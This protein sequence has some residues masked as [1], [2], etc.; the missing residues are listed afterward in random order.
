MQI[1]LTSLDIL[2]VGTPPAELRSAIDDFERRL[3]RHVTVRVRELKGE[4]LDRGERLVQDAEGERIIGAIERL[5]RSSATRHWVIACHIS[6]TQMTSEQ[7]AEHV[8]S[9][10]R[11]VVVVGGACGLAPSVLDRADMQLSL[12]RITL[13]HGMA[14]LVVTEQLYRSWKIAHG[15]PYHH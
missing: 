1:A 7:L 12:G 5:D 10:P 13:P 15:E 3:T 9:R 6:G 2:V 14:R 11:V 8:I 4:R